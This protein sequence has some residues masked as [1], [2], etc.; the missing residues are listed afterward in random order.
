MNALLLI[1]VLAQDR[2]VEEAKRELAAEKERIAKEERAQEEALKADLEKL[3]ALTD[4]VVDLTKALGDKT[5][6]LEALREERKNLRESQAASQQEWADARRVAKDA[7]KKLSDLLSVLPP[8]ENRTGQQKLLSE[9]STSGEGP[10]DASP[11]LALFDSIL[12]ETRTTAVFNDTL[13][14]SD[15]REKNV[16]VFRAGMI[17]HAYR[18]EDK[19]A[20]AVAAPG[21]EQGYRWNEALPSWACEAITRKEG[22]LPIDV[23]QQMSAERTYASRGLWGFL[24]AGGPVMIPLGLVALAALLLS[25]ERLVFL[26]RGSS[27]EIVVQHCRNGDF[28]SAERAATNEP[29]SRTILACVKKRDRGRTAM[30]EAVQESMLHELPRLERFLPALGVLAGIAP[31]LGLLGTVTGMIT[32]FDMITA[33]GNSE[34]GI[35][36]GGIS[37][38]LI[39]TVAGLVIA[40][41]VLLFHSYLSGRVERIVADAERHSATVIDL[42]EKSNG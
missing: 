39:T 34:P 37:E 5:E 10:F 20:M 3:G 11:L 40:I 16:E 33:F 17:L 36:A 6:E 8:S 41:P 12:S 18:S 2:A 7:H 27:A 35:M 14:T 26:S 15:G 22:M 38:A 13:R 19:V 30:E 32:T 4:Q 24:V 1:A 42:V 31:M 21:N 23:T 28:A 29:V 9:I 25:L